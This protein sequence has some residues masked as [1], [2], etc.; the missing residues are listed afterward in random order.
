MAATVGVAMGTSSDVTSE[1]AGAAITDNSLKN[2]FLHII[3]IVIIRRASSF[4]AKG[5]NPA[6]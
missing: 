6:A 1:A 5:K 2:E 4:R 3:R